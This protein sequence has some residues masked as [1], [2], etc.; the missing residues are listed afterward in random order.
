MRSTL[1]IHGIRSTAIIASM[2]TVV[3]TMSGC[4]Q[5][6]DY[7]RPEHNSPLSFR[8]GPET[9]DPTSIADLP[10]WEV[11]KDPTLQSLIRESVVNNYDLRIA[12]TRIEQARAIQAQVTSPLYPQ[13]GYQGGIGTGKNAMFG[14]PSP[15]NGDSESSALLTL[16]A[17]WE[18]DIWGRISRANEAALAQILAAEESHRAVMLTLTSSVAS[19]YIELIELDLELEIAR[20]TVTSFEQTLDLFSRRSD[21]GIGSR[22]QVFRAQAALSQVAATIPE[23]QRQ[24]TV[25]ENTLSVLLGRNPGPIA[26]GSP[27]LDQEFPVEIPVGIPSDIIQRRPDIRRA[28]QNVVSANAAIGVALANRFP[29]IGLTAFLGK[30]SPELSDFFDGSTNAWSVA[31]LASGPIFTGGRTQGEIDQARAIFAQYLLEYQNTVLTSLSEV[32]NSLIAR[33]RLSEVESELSKQVDAL[34]SAVKMSRERYDVGRASYFE[35]LDAQQQLYPAELS[36]ARAK[37]DQFIAIIQ[38]YKA[39]GGGWKVETVEW[40]ESPP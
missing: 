23:L 34:S 9:T 33:E 29:R 7:V 8:D 18:L 25:K 22:L 4:K 12:V 20:L 36:R 17:A 1:T 14:N 38:L 13:I 6:Q 24:I 21:G 31:A 37:A 15:T 30:V 3:G 40:A 10:W 35:I 2:L 19:N 32:A 5:G 16:N 27:L 28:E 26:R 39:L 11:F